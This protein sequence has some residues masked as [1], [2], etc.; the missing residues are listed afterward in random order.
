[1]PVPY[2]A[3]LSRANPTCLL[4][5][6]DQSSSMKEPFGG[7]SDKPKAQAVADAINRLL[8]NLVLKCAKSD[9][10]RDYFHIGVLGYG[11]QVSWALGGGLAGQSL[12]PISA[13]AAQPLRVEQRARK[14]DDGAGGLV[15]QKF[16]FPVWF[17]P[18]AGGKTSMCRALAMAAEALG[19]FI[20][21]FPNSFPPLVINI[22]DGRATDGDPRP[23][24]QQLRELATGDGNVLFF[25]A[26]LSSANA[27]PVEFPA[28]ESELPE[29][30]ARLLFR[31]SSVLPPKLEA[32]ARNDGFRVEPGA[33]GF[34]FNADLVSVVRF[35]DVGTRVAQTL[36]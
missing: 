17:E 2:T 36:R 12:V 16:K 3:E 23:A 20:G 34:V 19:V 30:H 27:R 9:G 6:I 29:P 13:V 33:R 25:N 1:L 35:L 31:M 15:E 7:Q 26:H 24:A 10:V 5:L 28:K 22:S 18:T 32:A 4:F 21:H 11:S 14:V 8:Q